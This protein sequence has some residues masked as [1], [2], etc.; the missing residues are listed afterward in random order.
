M[1]KFI[2]ALS[3]FAIAATAMG[4]AM[5]FS[6]DAAVN[7]KV[8]S[9]VVAFR[10]E[11]AENE[12][13][14]VVKVAKGG[15]SVPVA[16]YIP[17]SSG[18]YSIS[19]KL[20]INGAETLGKGTVEDWQKN[21]IE[22]YKYAFGNYGI[23][24]SDAAFPKPF[25]LDS[26]R[27][28]SEDGL[29]SR[30]GS[31]KNGM[32]NFTAD[33]F[34][35]QYQSKHTIT[36]D[37]KLYGGGSLNIDSYDAWKAT[38]KEDFEGYE[39]VWTWKDVDWG[40]NTPFVT[41][42]LD[43]PEDLPQGKYVLDVYMDEFY[44]CTPSAL[45]DENTNEELPDT[46]DEKTPHKTTGKSGVDGVD[47]SGNSV[48][49]K[50]ESKPLTIYVGQTSNPE[51]ETT[52]PEVKTTEPEV[53]TTEPEVKTTAPNPTTDEP[54]KVET[55][56]K[57]EG[58]K[59][60]YDLIPRGKEVNYTDVN[61]EGNNSCTAK[62][63][64]ELK[65]DWIVQ[66]DQGTA[67]LQMTWDFSQVDYQKAALGDAYEALPTFNDK[68]EKKG[69]VIYTFGQD[70][71][72]TAADKAVIYTFTVKV[73]E[74]EG[75][76]SITKMDGAFTKTISRTDELYTV[77]THGLDINVKKEDETTEPT[78]APTTAPTT[79][80]TTAPTT[81]PTAEPTTEPTTAPTEPGTTITTS[82]TVQTAAPSDVLYGDV[83]CD[84]KV[85]INDVVLLNRFFAKTADLSEQGAKNADCYNDGK[86]TIE[87]ST[88]LKDFLARL[89]TLPK[90]P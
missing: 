75:K 60:V 62:P 23:T 29:P 39:P 37:A 25:C 53:K 72:E 36:N 20:A 11:M 71:E 32:A 49:K 59:I 17:Q 5:A 16:A 43:L 8:D 47:D 65:I 88:A 55:Q 12:T 56:G 69:E 27:L 45:F 61:K 13:K 63:G 2:S 73:P 28:I 44:L 77:I 26:G 68:T 64:E 51:T 1:K 54:E 48:A 90:K 10:S 21:K 80:P 74:T 79:E 31:S 3:S 82:T 33:A 83:N 81:E 14:D 35:I 57:I 52:Q 4:G 85:K 38:G 46:G 84:G 50:L 40:Y 9:T 42:K 6:T 15:V 78:T 22:N 89:I 18:F 24:I 70:E 30:A 76:V 19:L 67:G 58:S 66:N 86:L 41:F 7:E 34:N 87:D